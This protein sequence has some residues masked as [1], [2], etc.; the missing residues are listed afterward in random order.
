MQY[1][2]VIGTCNIESLQD[3]IICCRRQALRD[4]ITTCLDTT[5][6]QLERLWEE[7]GIVHDQQNSRVEVV[8]HHLKGLLSSMVGEE[9]AL[10]DKLLTN[11]EKF[12]N[13]LIKLCRELH[14]PPHEVIFFTYADFYFY[15]LGV[16]TLVTYFHLGQ[17]DFVLI[18]HVFL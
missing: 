10:K 5:L 4:E 6:D 18:D 16:K 12:G 9:E 17:Q 2:D 3:T 7:I 15:A 13:E 11:T 8:M 1:C 14:L